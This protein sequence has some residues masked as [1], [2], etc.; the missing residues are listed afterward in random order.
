MHFADADISIY[1]IIFA[2]IIYYYRIVIVDKMDFSLFDFIK[3][4]DTSI[5]DVRVICFRKFKANKYETLFI[6]HNLQIWISSWYVNCVLII[7]I[8]RMTIVEQNAFNIC[9]VSVYFRSVCFVF[10]IDF[11]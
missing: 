4:V 5:W 2:A 11:H 6:S 8:H 10:N 9:M 1:S 7:T 3:I